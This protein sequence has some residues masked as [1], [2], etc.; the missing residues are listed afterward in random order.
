MPILVVAAGADRMLM[1]C[2][3]EA[4]ARMFGCEVASIPGVSHDLMLVSLRAFCDWLEQSR[5]GVIRTVAEIRAFSGVLPWSFP[6]FCAYRGAFRLHAC[7]DK[8]A[9]LLEV[10][11][12]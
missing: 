4:L 3:V 8:G 12:H 2:Q 11:E 6:T 9:E 7:S 1:P 10:S 5:Q